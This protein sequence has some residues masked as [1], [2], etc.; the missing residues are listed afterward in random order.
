MPQK[1]QEI[2][3]ALETLLETDDASVAP[4]LEAKD[5]V[6]RVLE[7][8]NTGKPVGLPGART[9]EH[10]GLTFYVDT[11]DQH[12][13]L[14]KDLAAVIAGE[15]SGPAIARLLRQARHVTVKTYQMDRGKLVRKERHF[16]KDLPTLIAGQLLL[17]RSDEQLRDDVKQCRLP[18]CGRFFLASDDVKDASA[19]GRRRHRYCSPEHMDLAQSSG[20]E[21]TRKWRENRK[22]LAA[23]KHK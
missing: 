21:R 3:K 19:P 1:P 20:A 13:E 4:A 11:G 15:L 5:L 9:V 22:K 2:A 10:V 8:A 18:G 23:A 12:V 7:F 17:I 6:R 14:R 16:V